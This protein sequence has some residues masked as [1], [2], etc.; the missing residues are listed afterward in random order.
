MAARGGAG[1]LL[2]I[3]S[4]SLSYATSRGS[5]AALDRLDLEM[6]PGEA[7]VVLG[8]SGCG[9]TSLVRALT[10]VLPGNAG[11][12]EGR[13]VLGGEEIS[14][15]PWEE[16][17]GRILWEKISVVTQS[18]M[19]SLNPVL[20]VGRQVAEPLLARRR[21]RPA[22]ARAKAAEAFRM[23]GLPVDY[24]DRYPLELSGGMRQRAVIAMALVTDPALVIL[25]EPT[26]ALDVI[27]QGAIMNALKRV[28]R[29]TGAGFL[30]ITHDIATSSQ[31]AD[32]VALMYAGRLVENSPAAEFFRAPAH[33]Y[34]R[35]LMKSVPRLLGSGE[36][37][38]VPGAPPD[39]F[40]LPS[41][42][43]FGPRCPER[44]EKCRREPPLIEWRPGSAARCWKVSK[45]GRG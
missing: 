13:V 19:N 34:A 29:E 23:V 2:R 16:F 37:V 12:P 10:R 28:R 6:G 17:R 14:S 11:E 5:L 44:F 21:A 38:H 4:L 41:G 42:C 32:R 31:L 25:D 8:E 26:S 15:L 40:E 24:L 43:L 1:P 18:A 36:P 30:L 35:L 27:C 20:R 9:K 45:G 7:L 39:P 22:E 33:P 3:E